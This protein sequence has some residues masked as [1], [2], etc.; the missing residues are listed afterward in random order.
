MIWQNASIE[1]SSTKKLPS[2]T[3]LKAKDGGSVIIFS[4]VGGL[5]ISV[6]LVLHEGKSR[7]RVECSDKMKTK[8][9]GSYEN[10]P[11]LS[12]LP[13]LDH[14]IPIPGLETDEKG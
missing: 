10:P 4:D 12:R 1:V 3:S 13:S 2:S 9:L 5:L 6:V 11:R 8:W 7:L 14:N